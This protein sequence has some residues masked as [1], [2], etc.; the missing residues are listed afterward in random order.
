[1]KTKRTSYIYGTSET[2]ESGSATPAF[3][4]IVQG[5]RSTKLQSAQVGQAAPNLYLVFFFFLLLLNVRP[6]AA[7]TESTFTWLLLVMSGDGL[8]FSLSPA[9]LELS[10]KKMRAV[11]TDTTM[12]LY[13]RRKFWFSTPY[14]MALRQLLK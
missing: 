13:S 1:M 6:V 3:T 11:H 14:T 5:S 2:A 12:R 10:W 7:Q 4:V 9:S 8:L